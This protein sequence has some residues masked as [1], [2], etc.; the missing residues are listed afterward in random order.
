M[1]E[2]KKK[3]NHHRLLFFFMLWVGQAAFPVNHESI[4]LLLSFGGPILLCR[5]NYNEGWK[6][7]PFAPHIPL[8]PCLQII[9]RTVLVAIFCFNIFNTSKITHKKQK[10]KTISTRTYYTHLLLESMNSNLEIK[11][12]CI[13]SVSVRVCNRVCIINT[14]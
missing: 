8:P 11:S 14:T 4:P 7:R 9:L 3:K 5:P 2:Q 10:G 6:S 13:S 12:Q 1:R